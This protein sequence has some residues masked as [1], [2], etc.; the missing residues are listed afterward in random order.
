MSNDAS[1]VS[2]SESVSGAPELATAYAGARE[3]VAEEKTRNTSEAAAPDNIFAERRNPAEDLRYDLPTSLPAPANPA[4]DYHPSR[5]PVQAAD[6]PSRKDP[7]DR[8]SMASVIS[9]L[10]RLENWVKTN[11][12]G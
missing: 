1:T 10:E 7:S 9:R 2:E 4:S 5:R 8:E 6:R 12:L 3:D 11:R